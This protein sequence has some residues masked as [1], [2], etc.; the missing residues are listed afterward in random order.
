MWPKGTPDSHFSSSGS[1][2]SF[3]KT[4]KNAGTLVIETLHHDL[5][6]PAERQDDYTINPHRCEIVGKREGVGRNALGHAV[7]R[8]A[9][10]LRRTDTDRPTTYVGISLRRPQHNTVDLSLHLTI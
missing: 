7:H 1:N 8:I 9:L 2:S 6:T 4:G 5:E 3:Y 10:K